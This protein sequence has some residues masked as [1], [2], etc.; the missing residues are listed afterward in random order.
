MAL[1]D[2]QKQ[3]AAL[4]AIKNPDAD[5]MIKLANDSAF[6]FAE[7]LNAAPK[8]KEELSKEKESHES[9]I[10][11]LNT[12]LAKLSLLL[13]SLEEIANYGNE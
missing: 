9:H 13:S 2:G 7:L 6:A 4:L 1:T 10:T 12:R 3:L 11:S 8:L 5:Y